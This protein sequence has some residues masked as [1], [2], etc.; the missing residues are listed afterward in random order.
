MGPLNGP[1]NLFW[2]PGADP[3]SQ[4][5]F[6]SFILISEAN[7]IIWCVTIGMFDDFVKWDPSMGPN[8][9]FW[10]QEGTQGP[11]THFFHFNLHKWGKSFNSICH[12]KYV[13]Q[14]WAIEP[15]S[16]GPLKPLFGPWRGPMTPKPIFFALTLMRESNP[17][18]WYVTR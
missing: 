1:K 10:G 7:P 18:I 11:K 16:M 9:H 8:T 13:S 14:L 12:S 3:G 4:N 15:P 17:L 2:G 5:P 6:I